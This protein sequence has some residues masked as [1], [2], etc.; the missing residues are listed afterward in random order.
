MSEVDRVAPWT[1]TGLQLQPVVCVCGCV[2]VC[3]CVCGCGCV[4]VCV[5]IEKGVALKPNAAPC[6]PPKPLKENRAPFKAAQ[7]I[8]SSKENT[9]IADS[10]FLKKEVTG[11]T[12]IEKKTQQST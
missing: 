6:S 7:V 2:G 12:F 8:S 10:L 1:G 4:C 5:R 11:G 3:V 9:F